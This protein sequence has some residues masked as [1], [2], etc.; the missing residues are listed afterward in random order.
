M[1]MNKVHSARQATE[2]APSRRR[3][4]GLLGGGV[5]HVT[6]LGVGEDEDR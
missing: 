5:W 4:Y 2:R 6:P 3:N 1:T